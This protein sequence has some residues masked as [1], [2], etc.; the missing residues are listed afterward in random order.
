MHIS[1]AQRM[2][3][4]ML[5]VLRDM[6]TCAPPSQGRAHAAMAVT[7]NTKKGARETAVVCVRTRKA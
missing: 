3:S 4:W 7:T 6:L 1:A 2:P 5:C